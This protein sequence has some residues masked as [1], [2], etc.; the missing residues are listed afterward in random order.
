MQF[1]LLIRLQSLH[2]EISQG[3]HTH[4][5][6]GPVQVRNLMNRFLLHCQSIRQ[7][8]QRRSLSGTKRRARRRVVNSLF[9]AA[10]GDVY[11]RFNAELYRLTDD[12]SRWIPANTDVSLDGY[13]QMAEHEDTLYIVSDAETLISVDRGK[14]W[15]AQGS[16]SRRA[17]NWHCHNR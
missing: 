3:V 11:A 4:R 2:Y 13:W 7:K 9:V 16:T 5:V 6:S 10:N 12:R 15:N 17:I 1:L 14:T 8:S